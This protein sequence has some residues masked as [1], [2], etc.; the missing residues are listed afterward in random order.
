MTFFY[1][2]TLIIMEHVEEIAKYIPEFSSLIKDLN[3][4]ISDS[5]SHI[6]NIYENLTKQN[7]VNHDDGLSFLGM[8]CHLLL[9]YLINLSYIILLKLEGESLIDQP[10]VER[11][12]EIR[13][14][15]EK[16][17]PIDKKLKYQIDKLI[18]MANESSQSKGEK[19]PLSYKP[20]LENLVNKE[21]A[22][23]EVDEED[24]KRGSGVYV[25]P[26]L[27]AVPYG[28]GNKDSGLDRKLEKAKRKALNSALIDDLRNEYGES[29]IEIRDDRNSIKQRKLRVK[30]D[31]RVQFEEDNL[32]RLTL[33]KKDKLMKRKMSE[34]DEVIKL[35]S[36]RS[37]KDES[38][39]DEREYKPATKKK[40]K[41]KFSKGKFKKRMQRKR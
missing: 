29:P 39:E 25:P 32:R 5:T 21:D 34:L 30:E 11:L 7:D 8:K 28:E 40:K 13:T 38:S 27:T 22:E 14:V 16:I 20:S 18:K 3:A 41:G 4:S 26:K 36:F 12:V 24:N 37:F 17:R 19:H 15:L 2:V 1:L 6:K 35:G 9:K 33:T 10:S 23:S 31:E